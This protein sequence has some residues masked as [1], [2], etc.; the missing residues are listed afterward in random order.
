[1]IGYILTVAEKESIQGVEY[2]PFQTFNCV[3]DINGVWFTFLTPE[4]K[5]LITNTSY[6]WIM[7]CPTGEYTPPPPPPIL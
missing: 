7:D 3:K 6:S 5:V 1:M 4:D 2:A